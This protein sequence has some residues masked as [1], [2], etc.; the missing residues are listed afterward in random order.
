MD[1]GFCL[2]HCWSKLVALRLG[3]F[4]HAVTDIDYGIKAM[5]SG[6]DSE[7]QDLPQNGVSGF[8]NLR[9]GAVRV[10]RALGQGGAWRQGS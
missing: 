5:A 2:L 6:R 10:D 3:M 8:G 7:S 4:Y 1:Y 9:A